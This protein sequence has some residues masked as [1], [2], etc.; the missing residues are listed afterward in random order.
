[1]QGRVN[2]KQNFNE[3]AN[4]NYIN[5]NCWDS[6]PDRGGPQTKI[7]RILTITIV[8]YTS[9]STNSGSITLFFFRQLARRNLLYCQEMEFPVPLNRP[10][11]ASWAQCRAKI[12]PSGVDVWKS[13]YPT[14]T[15]CCLFLGVSW[16]TNNYMGGPKN[17]SD[18]FVQTYTLNKSHL[19]LNH[20]KILLCVALAWVCSGSH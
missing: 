16:I 14:N 19:R 11:G 8:R 17:V 20:L 2:S 15:V 12:K 1:M 3:V 9:T 13:N 18:F 7:S 6:E 10:S 5:V 4:I